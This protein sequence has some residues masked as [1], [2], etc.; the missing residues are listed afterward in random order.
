MIDPL[1]TISPNDEVNRMVCQ[2]FTNN[3]GNFELEIEW[4]GSGQYQ[5]LGIFLDVYSRSEITHILPELVYTQTYFHKSAPETWR[6]DLK[7][8]FPYWQNYDNT[9]CGVGELY[10][11]GRIRSEYVAECDLPLKAM[12]VGSYEIYLYA[13]GVHSSARAPELVNNETGEY[14]F[15]DVLRVVPAMNITKVPQY[16]RLTPGSELVFEATRVFAVANAP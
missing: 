6:L 7:G 5:K 11:P 15:H 9:R 12:E 1:K 2:L 14:R 8:I 13:N 16:T 10:V 3:T 4:E